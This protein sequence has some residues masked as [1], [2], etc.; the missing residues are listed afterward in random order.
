MLEPGASEAV[1]RITNR[2]HLHDQ[3]TSDLQGDIEELQREG[4]LS[5]CWPASM[6]GEG[7][8]SEPRGTVAAFTAL[9]A[10]G[11][12]NLSLAR[13]F[14]GH[15]NACKLVT[16]YGSDAQVSASVASVRNG[17]LLGVWGAN[18]ANAPLRLQHHG[19]N[20][21]RI[22]HLSGAKVFASG[23][24]YVSQAIV[25]A[26]Y[27]GAE[28]LLLIPANDENRA[29]ASTWDMSGM[30]A[31]RSGRY[32]F[33]GVELA[34]D[35][36]IGALD[37]YYREPF[38]EGGIW[39]YCAAHLGAAEALYSLTRDALIKRKRASDPHQQR[40]VVEM[41]I[42]LETT[43]LLLMRAACEVEEAGASPEKI[44]L[45]LLAREHTHES[46]RTVLALSE[47]AL[48]MTA[49]IAGTPVERIRRDLSL[50]LCQAAP[51]A[52]RARAAEILVAERKL[53]ENL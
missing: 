40:R 4:W 23:L 43:R 12:A 2:A 15:M 50:F 6:G 53:P 46:C 18:D 44:A 35:A 41:A 10:L 26:Q 21:S 27:N 52:K 33:T 11:T 30:R 32:D 22:L 9:R 45:S 36:L 8:G 13:L 3:L 24:G 38:F 17:N 28:Q 7:W 37:D 19:R 47:Q 48:G 49:H 1:Q 34:D 31:T 20:G 39:R 14:E 16:L 5:A 25:T 42:A 51:D 29:D